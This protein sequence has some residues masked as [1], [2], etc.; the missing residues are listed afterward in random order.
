ME[1]V[2]FEKRVY[3]SETEGSDRRGRPFGRWNDKVKESMNERGT[4]RGSNKQR[5]SVW[6]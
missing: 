5:G 6:T 2:E 3:M 1:S 4:G